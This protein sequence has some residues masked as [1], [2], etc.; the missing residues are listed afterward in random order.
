MS[1]TFPA[2]NIAYLWLSD[3]VLWNLQ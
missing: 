3:L 1:T 2:A